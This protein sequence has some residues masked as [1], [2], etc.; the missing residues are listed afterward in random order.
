MEYGLRNDLNIYSG[1][2]GLLSG[3]TLKSAADLGRKLI[4]V[5]LLYRDGYF[6]QEVVEG[7]QRQKA[8]PWNP[9]KHPGLIDLRDAISIPIAGRPV[10]FRLWGYKVPGIGGEYVP[11]ILLDS[12]GASNSRGDEEIT[13]QLYAAGSWTRL[14]QEIA[15]GIGGVQALEWCGVPIPYYHMNEGH[16]A[17]LAAKVLRMLFEKKTFEELTPDDFQKVKALLSFTTHTPVEAGFDK[18]EVGQIRDAFRDQFLR[19]AVLT[20]GRDPY[21]QSYINMARLAMSLSGIINGVSVLHARVSQEMFPEFAPIIIP[22]TNGVHHLT[23]ASPATAAFLDESCPEWRKDPTK[24]AELASLKGDPAFREKLWRAHQENKQALLQMVRKTTK[25][26][27]SE[28][29]YTIGIAR[30]FATY[31]RGDLIFT[32]EEELLRLAEENGGLQLIFAGK[33]HPEDGFGKNIIAHVIE[34]GNRLMERSGGKIKFV[35]LPNYNIEIAAAMVA[36]VD[37]WLNNPLRPHEASGTS[38]MKAA[39]NGVPQISIEDGWWAENRGGGWSF[40][41][42]NL[43]PHEGDWH[44]YL[45]DSAS[46]YQTLAAVMKAYGGRATDPAFV[47]RMVE[48][49]AGNGAYFN[50]HRMVLQYEEQVWRPRIVAPFQPREVVE[51][52][53][54]LPEMFSRLGRVLLAIAEAKKDSE[55]E[56]LV[57]ES[58]VKNLRGCQRVSR[59]DIRHE[60]VKLASRW[61]GKNNGEIFFQETE[62]DIG[63]SNFNHWTSL[64][65]F[66]GEVMATLLKEKKMQ[67]VPDPKNDQRCYRDGR[68]VSAEPFVLVP[69]IINGELMGAYK[70]DFRSGGLKGEEKEIAFLI[71]LMEAV[72]V[73]KSKRL[74]EALF[75]DLESLKTE[76]EII[77]WA[78]VLMTAGG[79]VDLS[80]YAVETNRAAVFLLNAEGELEGRQAI[81]EMYQKEWQ[82]KVG[83]ILSEIYIAGVQKYLRTYDQSQASLNLHIRGKKLG[84]NL[85]SAP[86]HVQDGIALFDQREVDGT[87]DTRKLKE[88]KDAVE[89]IFAA[90]GHKIENYL[91]LPVIGPDGIQY[92]L[93]YVDNAFSGKP[94]SPEKCLQIVQAAVR[95][96]AR[97]RASHV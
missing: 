59:Y 20:L 47:D 77:N 83:R 27:M 36:G 19:T 55:V 18:F 30:R 57:A 40:G 91:L 69:E 68:L 14:T 22:I 62:E 9:G 32:N 94:F 52:E 84:Q 96:I 45:A 11:L 3:D 37:S 97:I 70:I 63:G 56:S 44:L 21:N 93:V 34:A 24:L 42:T 95:R 23:W 15:L 71:T 90:D 16:S 1:G 49:I 60:L 73:T 51:P 87:F 6:L 76:D 41:D 66:S 39:L 38:G 72:G 31:K 88:L 7:R 79:F 65:E 86:V 48:A 74:T 82:G 33:A 58:L 92:G 89:E 2:L 26:Q 75:E 10:N 64:P 61:V 67:M 25:V 50:T 78:L 8:Q 13:S 28:D 35:F 53:I 17:F 12:R 5:G 43:E 85:I 80:R 4:A 46:L 81:G 29:V 54:L